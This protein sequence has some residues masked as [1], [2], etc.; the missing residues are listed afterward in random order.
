M[1]DPSGSESEAML[2]MGKKLGALDRHVLKVDKRLS[3]LQKGMDNV[4]WVLAKQVRARPCM[5]LCTCVCA[6]SQALS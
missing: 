5:C 1:Q 4:L 6:M 3:E 2:A